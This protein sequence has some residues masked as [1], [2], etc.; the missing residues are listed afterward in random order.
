MSE[1]LFT[2]ALDQEEFLSTGSINDGENYYSF[3]ADCGNCKYG[4]LT[5]IKKGFE[6]TQAGCPNCHCTKLIKR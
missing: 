1:Q 4:G 6:I 5:F 3:Y 2:I